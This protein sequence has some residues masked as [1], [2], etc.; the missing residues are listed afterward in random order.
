MSPD[1]RS[2]AATGSQTAFTAESRLRPLRFSAGAGELDADRLARG[3]VGAVV[4][5][6]LAAC[7][8]P[9]LAKALLVGVV[10]RG[11]AGRLLPLRFDVLVLAVEFGVDRLDL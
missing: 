6:D 4:R 3:A 1:Y 2:D 9:Q 8:R 11:N 5:D 10:A 7:S